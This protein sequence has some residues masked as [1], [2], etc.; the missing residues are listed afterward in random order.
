MSHF[1]VTNEIH[2]L[3]EVLGEVEFILC[4]VIPCYIYSIQFFLRIW[5]T[6]V[7]GPTTP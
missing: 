3:E 4:S 2:V 6:L 7:P 5:A 1:V